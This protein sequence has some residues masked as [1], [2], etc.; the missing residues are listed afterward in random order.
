MFKIK[1]RL[2]IK[3]RIQIFQSFIQSHLNYCSLAWGFSAKSHIHSLFTKQKQ[4]VRAIMPG[5]I[6]YWFKDGELPAHT[7]EKF[8]EYKILSVHGIIVKNALIF[9]HKCLH[10]PNTLPI[11][12]KNLIPETVP[13]YNDNIDD[14]SS[15]VEKYNTP[16]FR[17]SFFYKG[18]LLAI[19][20]ENFDS[21]SS[22]NVLSIEVYKTYIKEMLLDQQSLGSDEKWP[23]FLLNRIP[24][25]RKSTRINSE[26]Y[27]KPNYL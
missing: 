11:S 1:S 14:C 17:S 2:P 25:L 15:W 18:H 10:F 27:K 6:N 12:I 7:K 16:I 20:N 19:T 3:V 8:K 9:M 4:G 24:G 23:E 21:I 26:D 13:K 22:T 5:Y